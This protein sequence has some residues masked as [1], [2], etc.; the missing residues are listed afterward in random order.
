MGLNFT[1]S[2]EEL[3]TK[4]S[5]L[6]GD[7]DDS[8]LNKKVFKIKDG[9][10]NWFESPD[11]KINFQGKGEGKTRLESEVP[12]LLYP[13]EGFDNTKLEPAVSNILSDLVKETVNV[14]DINSFE[15]Q[16][17]AT[18]VNEGELVIGIISAVGT[19]SKHLIDALKDRLIPFGYSS[20][21]IRVSSILPKYTGSSEYDQQFSL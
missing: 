6:N 19:E 16:Y 2:Y 20:E 14:P 18:G 9:V 11:G 13:K 21:E 3:Q 4:L 7:W 8:Q 1:G 10:M 15:R 17:L 5:S 12:L